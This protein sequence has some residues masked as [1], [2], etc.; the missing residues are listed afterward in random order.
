M[1]RPMLLCAAAPVLLLA[2]LAMLNLTLAQEPPVAPAP[3]APPALPA[4]PAQVAPPT[5][6]APPAAAPAPG[7]YPRPAVRVQALPPGVVPGEAPSADVLMPLTL[8][9]G[10]AYAF[11]ENAQSKAEREKESQARE[12]LDRY[13]K[14][15]DESE[16]GRLLEELTTV[17]G[18]QFDLRQERR[19]QEL[20]Q[21]EEQLKRLRTLHQRRAQEKDRIVRDRVQQLV[22]ES[23]GL[24]WGSGPSPG[25]APGVGVPGYPQP[26]SV[27]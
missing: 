15:E 2:S 4:L 3:A 20:K 18:S 10:T 16:R 5:V 14:S 9:G 26:A 13:S 24:G 22:R 8:R 11:V 19:E 17:A 27:P 1:N 25:V 23:E 6:P 12:L 21:L 7:L